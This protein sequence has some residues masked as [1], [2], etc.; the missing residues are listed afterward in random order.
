MGINIKNVEYLKAS[1]SDG[2]LSDGEAKKLGLT[3]SEQAKLQSLF[4]NGG[5]KVGETVISKQTVAEAKKAAAVKKYTVNGSKSGRYY[6][7]DG[8]GKKTY[9]AANGKPIK[10]AY[11]WDKEGYVLKNGKPEKKV[12]EKGWW[13]RTKEA[14]KAGWDTVKSTVCDEDGNFSWKKTGETAAVMA[15]AGAVIVGV[16]ALLVAAEA[17][18]AA[19]VAMAWAVPILAYLHANLNAI[20]MGVFTAAIAG[21]A[22]QGAYN[23][24]TA[25]TEK[26]AQA[27]TKQMG[28]A[29]GEGALMVL[30]SGIGK[31]CAKLG[32]G[33]YGNKIISAFKNYFSKGK[34]KAQPKVS[35]S[36]SQGSGTSNS[37]AKASTSTSQGGG[38]SNSS[39]N[40]STSKSQGNGTSSHNSTGNS[41]S[42]TQKASSLSKA[43]HQNTQKSSDV[44]RQQP[45]APTEATSETLS[46]P[47]ET[48]SARSGREKPGSTNEKTASKTN[49]E[50]TKPKLT[51][52]QDEALGNYNSIKYE[53]EN[54]RRLFKNAKS[55]KRRELLEKQI[56]GLE[57]NLQQY[58][59]E[60]RSLGIDT[61]GNPLPKTET[62]AETKAETN[63]GANSGAKT[64]TKAESKSGA[65][66]E[67]KAET[68]AE[69]APEPKFGYRQRLKN[70]YQKH[71][72]VGTAKNTINGVI[73]ANNLFGTNDTN[74]EPAFA[75]DV[76]E[77]PD[78]PEAI[79]AS[80]EVLDEVDSPDTGD[81]PAD[82]EL[83]ATEE[84]SSPDLEEQNL[85]NE[86]T[87]A[88]AAS[89]AVSNSSDV[90]DD[91]PVEN[92]TSNSTTEVVDGAGNISASTPAQVINDD[93][94]IDNDNISSTSEFPNVIPTK[95]VRRKHREIN[96]VKCE[97]VRVKDEYGNAHWY[98]VNPKD[99][100]KMSE[101]E[102]VI[103]K[104]GIFRKNKFYRVDGT[105]IPEKEIDVKKVEID[106]KE[107]QV[108]NTREDKSQKY[109]LVENENG[110]CSK[111]AEVKKVDGKWEIVNEESVPLENLDSTKK[112]TYSK[113]KLAVEI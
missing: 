43:K 84:D 95:N 8:N 79:P 32:L 14:A 53:L 6:T 52:E 85:D 35:T 28:E 110:I 9:Y 111:G 93:S 88:A 96:G 94:S 59:N 4:E 1:F 21:K 54:A 37:S 82:A 18:C 7:I 58:E 26:E 105:T 38:T 25:T 34:P 75:P 65:N 63:T 106:D 76:A 77:V 39:A 42:S 33:K 61:K 108:F 60:L 91:T 102:L 100:S 41:S 20:I 31:V 12:E 109:I 27:A 80:A 10:E 46:K 92:I 57:G 103:D 49:A 62:K 24:S 29:A 45:N 107:F 11:F 101:Q 3:K 90:T 48:S 47:S 81:I 71:I 69:P 30:F 51:K 73:L 13:A 87:T 97:V 112:R 55:P 89:D 23:M 99:P 5:I 19:S 67:S 83:P 36:T 22:V 72:P 15:A 104:R 64:E 40:A 98:E 17:A 56:E 70:I 50:G 78:L 113:N 2:V 44:A 74:V 16:N 86:T 66:T 68:S